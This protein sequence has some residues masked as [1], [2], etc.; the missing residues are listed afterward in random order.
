MSKHQTT[1]WVLAGIP[2]SAGI[3]VMLLTP[4]PLYLLHRLD[5]TSVLP[6]LWLMTLLHLAW[7]AV[8]GAFLGSVACHKPF[9]RSHEGSFWR[10]C[11]CLALGC[12]MMS[13]WYILLFGKGALLLSWGVLPLCVGMM[14]LAV[15]SLH[16]LRGFS[17]WLA[18][19]SVL[20]P[21]LLA[22]LHLMVLLRT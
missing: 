2:L 11:T 10:G 20:W 22:I 21:I 15:L 14:L 12:M 13:V 17:L 16:S 8:V 7:Y 5:A 3:G 19:P 6:P 9:R 4:S 1:L 18:I